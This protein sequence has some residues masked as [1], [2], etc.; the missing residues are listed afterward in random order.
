MHWN[1]GF[2]SMLFINH[3]EYTRNVSFLEST[4]YPI[5]TGLMDWWACY[6]TKTNMTSSAT[7]DDNVAGEGRGG[8]K[9]RSGGGGSDEFRRV[10][11][12]STHTTN[13]TYELV[14]WP[15]QAAEGQTVPN[16][17]LALAFIARIAHQL[18]DMAEVLGQ[19]PHPAAV[20]INRHLAP[21]N[22]NKSSS[23]SQNETTVWTNFQVG[24]RAGE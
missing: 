8:N 21:F 13:S 18:V 7:K 24:R 6:L 19:A 16:P 20:D 4:T 2:A 23:S 1:G 15:D 3:W 5:L 22:T 17:Q 14:D 9:G 12:E 11:S 10:S